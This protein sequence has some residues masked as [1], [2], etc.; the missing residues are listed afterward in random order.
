MSEPIKKMTKA[1]AA[2]LSHISRAKNAPPMSVRF[3]LKVDIKGDSD[4]WNWKAGSRKGGYGTFGVGCKNL[5]SSRVA[6]ELT[7]GEIPEG[8]R[9]LHKCDNPPCCNPS[10][11]F[12]GTNAENSADMVSKKRHRHGSK[13]KLAKLTEEQV[14]EIKK[15]IPA[16]RC[17]R[18]ECS[19]IAGRFGITIGK[20]GKLRRGEAWSHVN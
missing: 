13:H 19:E 18:G 7:Y 20:L 16:G 5:V 8:L 6:W 11:L 4:C 12:L 17:K 2:F 14:S 15:L 1:E 3:W 9:V 10:H